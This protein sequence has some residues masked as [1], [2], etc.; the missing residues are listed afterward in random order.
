[1]KSKYDS[2]NGRIHG[3]IDWGPNQ[4]KRPELS[5]HCGYDLKVDGSNYEH[6]SGLTWKTDNFG[7]MI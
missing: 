5:L 7:W 6:Y 4:F 2:S 1:M 3:W